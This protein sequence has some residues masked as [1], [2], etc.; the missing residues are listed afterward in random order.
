MNI[1]LGEQVYADKIQDAYRE[2]ISVLY[3]E[4]QTSKD[5]YSDYNFNFP[6]MKPMESYPQNAKG[7]QN[8]IN[9]ICRYKIKLESYMKKSTK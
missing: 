2:N 5:K 8:Y 7:V 9:D 3:S 4:I 1:Y 6:Q